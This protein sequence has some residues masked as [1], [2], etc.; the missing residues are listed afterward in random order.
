MPTYVYKCEGNKHGKKVHVIEVQQKMSDAP[1]TLCT[2]CGRPAHRIIA[3]SGE[4]VLR[5]NDW[6]THSNREF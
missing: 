6:T 5:G 1:L 2:K 3:G 4:F